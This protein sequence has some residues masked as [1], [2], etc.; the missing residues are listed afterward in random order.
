MN[1][2]PPLNRILGVLLAGGMSSRMGG[3]DKCLR[4]IGGKSILWHVIERVRPQVNSLII[5]ANGDPKRFAE[6]DLPV[7]PDSIGGFAGPLAGVLAGLDWAAEHKPGI[8]H[9]VTVPTDG[10]FVPNDLVIRLTRALAKEDAEL[11]TA[12]SGGHS[13]PVVGLWP[14]KLRE[15][16]RHGMIQDDIRKVDR[17]TARHRLATADFK[18][19]PIDPFFNAN[20][21][22]DLAQA[23]RILQVAHA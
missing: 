16:L 20:T 10:P 11:S 12:S 21:P 17:W 5:N 4:E 3:G 19:Q 1:E 6:Y 13:H 18:T 9:I 7:V 2:G 22:E 23:E 8:T 15:D 14:V